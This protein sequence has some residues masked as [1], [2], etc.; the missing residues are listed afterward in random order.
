MVWSLLAAVLQSLAWYDATVATRPAAGAL[1][2]ASAPTF[3]IES[4]LVNGVKRL[5]H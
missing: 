3:E 4:V 1:F 5:A 2:P